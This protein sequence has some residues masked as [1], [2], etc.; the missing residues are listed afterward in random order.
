MF[1]CTT[2]HARAQRHKCNAKYLNK[3]LQNIN[4]EKLHQKENFDS[5]TLHIVFVFINIS[6][7]HRVLQLKRINTEALI[8]KI[9]RQMSQITF[10]QMF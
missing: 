6:L 2:A 10:V 7:E 3:S 9:R 1:V 8:K 5:P 4:T